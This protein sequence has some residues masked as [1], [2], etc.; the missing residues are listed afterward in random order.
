MKFTQILNTY[1]KPAFAGLLALF[2]V[3]VTAQNASAGLMFYAT[4]LGPLSDETAFGSDA[5]TNAIDLSSEDFSGFAVGQDLPIT[6]QNV[7]ITSNN[8]SNTAEIV[9]DSNGGPGKSIFFTSPGKITFDFTS[10]FAGGTSAFGIDIFDVGTIPMDS[11]T[12]TF[13]TSDGSVTYGMIG[14]VGPLPTKGLKTFVGVISD[15]GPTI[16]SVTIE[17][18]SGT[19]GEDWIFV[20][21]LQFETQVPEPGSIAIFGLAALGLGAGSFRR[22]R[23]EKKA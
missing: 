2:A 1:R 4:G 9:T 14:P 19:F 22:R 11:T 5:S 8:G 3:M 15:S 20:D 12:L 21:N 16:T 23:N 10:L 6:A 7:S 18:T 13:E 17:A